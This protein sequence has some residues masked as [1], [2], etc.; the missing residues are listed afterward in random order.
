MQC[1]KSGEGC[2]GNDGST[3]HQ[4]HDRGAGNG[5]SACDGSSDSQAP[6][7]V[8]IEA[9]H[10]SA[11][12]HT[13]SHQQEEDPDDPSE[14]TRELVGPE[15]EHL[16]HMNEN[17]RHHEVGAPSMHGANEPA[18]RHLMIQSLQTAPSFAS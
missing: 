11:E 17:N 2:A 15:Q 7:G 16:H 10:L 3:Q 8:L 5:Y 18:E 1:K 12:G 13:Q 4:F 14:F 6:V 9:K